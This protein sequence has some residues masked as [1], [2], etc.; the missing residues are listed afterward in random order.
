MAGSIELRDVSVTRANKEPI[1]DHVD[2]YVEEGESVALVGRSGAGKTTALKLINGLVKPSSGR[3]LVD[4]LSLEATDLV[5]LRRRI[6]TIIQ[7]AGLL[8]H[9]SI[10]DNVTLVPRLRGDDLK[11]V[12]PEARR[13]LNA[14]LLPFEEFRDRFPRTL[15]GGEQQRV[16][17]ARALVFAPEILLCDEPFAALDPIVRREQQEMFNA[18]RRERSV[19][20]LF[21]THDLQEALRMAPRI[22]M[23]EEGKLI[24]DHPAAA[25]I[26][27][28]DSRVRLLVSSA[29]LAD[30]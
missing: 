14:L 12:E 21:V 28:R 11:T 8:P 22:V 23:F 19:T 7:G 15:S 5:Q 16:G 20:M 29:G 4:G 2:L 6:G 25:F 1:L 10:Y 24:A 18:L 17:I 13:L 27:S 9:R 30:S 26:S 3:V